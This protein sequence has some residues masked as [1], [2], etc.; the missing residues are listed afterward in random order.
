MYLKSVKAIILSGLISLVLFI[1]AK[2]DFPSIEGVVVKGMEFSRTIGYPTVNLD[3]DKDIKLK[4]GVYAGYL[5]YQDKSY[6]GVMNIG[7]TPTFETKRPKL[8]FYIFDFNQNLY[9]QKVKI[10]PVSY[11][12]P[13]VKY[14]DL[15]LLTEAIAEDV[16]V[17]KEIL[18]YDSLNIK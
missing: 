3:L 8:E 2:A 12:R 18:K 13:E 17:A 6:A 1:E 4:Y 9:G 11:I 5:V 16:K 7:I 10:I 15:N 14:N